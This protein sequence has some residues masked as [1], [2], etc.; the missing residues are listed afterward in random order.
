MV[1]AIAAFFAEARAKN[2][3]QVAV[4]A[5]KRTS[6]IASRG[7]VSLA[8]YSKESG[9][10]AQALAQLAQA[11]RLNSENREASSLTAAIL[12]QLSWH[13]PVSGA[14][15][16]EDVVVSAQFSPDGQRV[17]AASWD[18]TARQRTR[19]D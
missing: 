5:T 10:N 14:M 17:V 11:L 13:V 15:W 4:A 12:T 3:T 6:E 2:Q 16:H 7:N 8:R 18:K 1:L 19:Q 9:K